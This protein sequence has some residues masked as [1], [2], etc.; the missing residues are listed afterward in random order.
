[1]P[2][3][4]CATLT[5]PR[6]RCRPREGGDPVAGMWGTMGPR[7]RGDDK[8]RLTSPRISHGAGAGIGR[9]MRRELAV[10]L[11]EQREAIR[12]SI[13]RAGGNQR[14]VLRRYR[15]VDDEA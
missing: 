6:I 12:Q 4:D 9:G 13:L 5:H 11:A 3:R 10:E 1:M 7:L 2:C 8:P 15:A 14:G